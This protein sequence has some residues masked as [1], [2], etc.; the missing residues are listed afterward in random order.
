MMRISD[1]ACCQSDDLTF[2][3]LCTQ[4]V[5]DVIVN[6]EVLLQHVL[7]GKGFATLV[8]AVALH[9]WIKTHTY[10]YISLTFRVKQTQDQ[11]PVLSESLDNI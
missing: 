2:P 8:A 3:T 1:E 11:N 5:S 10:E 7:P 9:S 4:E 6:P